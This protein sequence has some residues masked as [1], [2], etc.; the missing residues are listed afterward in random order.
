[1]TFLGGA[2]ASGDMLATYVSNYDFWG[3]SGAR[4]MIILGSDVGPN[5]P[6][7]QYFTASLAGLSCAA[8]S[9][10]D[11]ETVAERFQTTLK[12]IWIGFD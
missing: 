8:T 1:M 6:K 3:C 11:F 10:I 12:P 7:I 2:R 4:V 9:S 5:F